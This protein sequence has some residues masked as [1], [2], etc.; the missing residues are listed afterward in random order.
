MQPIEI[1]AIKSDS[2]ATIAAIKEASDIEGECIGIDSGRRSNAKEEAI[3][4]RRSWRLR[5]WGMWRGRVC[6]GC[7]ALKGR[8]R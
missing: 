5:K 4:K 8:L 3:E 2:Q 6:V 1:Q 7:M